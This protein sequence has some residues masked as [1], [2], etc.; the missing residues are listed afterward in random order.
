VCSNLD[1]FS[2]QRN[3]K[4]SGKLESAAQR[5]HDIAFGFDLKKNNS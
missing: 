3:L 2:G 4:I 5:K 1:E